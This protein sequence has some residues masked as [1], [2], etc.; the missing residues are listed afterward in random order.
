MPEEMR[1][2]EPAVEGQEPEAEVQTAAEGQE[3]EVGQ[4]RSFDA[5]YVQSLRKEA[6]EYRRRMRE[7]QQKLKER[8]E[9]ELSEQERLQHRLTEYEARVAELERDRQER[10]LKY[11]VMLAAR[12]KGVQDVDA[13][14]KLLDLTSI[15]F[16]E[17]GRPVN[18][19]QAL[20][21]L[22]QARPWLKGQTLPPVSPTNP[23]RGR[24]LTLDEIKR[25]SPDEINRN[26][27]AV[28]E[29]LKGG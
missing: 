7:L 16:D 25:M 18:I 13:A 5:A 23:P 14:Y 8:E 9:A 20:D 15:E 27:D 21:A 3:P 11:E 12:A 2:Q 6:A 19:D 1:G 29:V 17:D 4:Q 26:W 28:Q 22:L 10:T 24:R